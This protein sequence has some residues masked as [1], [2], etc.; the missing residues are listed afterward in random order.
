MDYKQSSL[1][2]SL[3]QQPLIIVIRLENDFFSKSE[4]REQLFIN[5]SNFSKKGIIHLEIGWDP[6][7]EWPNLI[8]E[9]Q[10]NFKK[11]NIGAASI[12]CEEALNS[13]IKLDLNYSMS[14][15]FRKELHL[16]A[17][18]YNQLLIPG[19]S[20][21]KDYKEAINLGYKIIKIFP[22]SNLG[23]SFIK[24][25]KQSETDNIFFIGAGGIK[26]VDLN[27]WFRNGYDALTIGRELNNQTID[28]HLKIWLSHYEVI[29]S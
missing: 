13:I 10:S 1:I 29:S 24:K 7:A 2:N 3:K 23:Y 14:P 12:T 17:Q 16:K 4:R 8:S 21:S 9:L 19:I 18:N 28:R 5:I 27:Q 20:N 22:A 6:N 15:I 26:S 25:L 11:I